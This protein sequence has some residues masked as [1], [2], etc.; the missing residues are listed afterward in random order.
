MWPSSKVSSL[1]IIFLLSSCLYLQPILLL[2]TMDTQL[3]ETLFLHCTYIESINLLENNSKTNFSNTA[4]VI[5]DPNLLGYSP[6]L[7]FFRQL[8]LNFITVK[9]TQVIMDFQY[10]I[11]LCSQV[12]MYSGI[13]SIAWS[14]AFQYH[15]KL[16]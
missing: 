7:E 1:Q 9:G 6:V 2:A 3:F 12:L 8:S 15:Y 13:T 11:S 5:R 10:S 4:C 16:R 14:F